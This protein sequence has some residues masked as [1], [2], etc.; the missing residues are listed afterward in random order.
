MYS[1]KNHHQAADNDYHNASNEYHNNKNIF[2]GNNIYL[3]TLFIQE[4]VIFLAQN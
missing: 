4:V 1:L 3:E 2:I